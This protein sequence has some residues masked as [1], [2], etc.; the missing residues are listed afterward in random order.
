[1]FFSLVVISLLLVSDSVASDVDP[2]NE[3]ED[4]ME[5]AMVSLSLRHFGNMDNIT[6]VSKVYFFCYSF[7]KARWNSSYSFRQFLSFDTSAKKSFFLF[8]K[9]LLYISEKGTVTDKDSVLF[10]IN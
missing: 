5:L 2:D 4:E 7:S 9:T 10:L 3:G 1:M 8:N 6:F